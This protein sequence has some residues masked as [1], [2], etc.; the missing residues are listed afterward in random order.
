MGKKLYI[1]EKPS[2]AASF[3]EVLGM[4][5]TKQD[6]SRGYAESEHSVVTWCFG[7]LITMAYPDAYDPKYREWKVE[8]LPIIPEEYKYIV[9]DDQGVKKQFETIKT[10]MLRED[11]DLIYAC[12]DSGREGEYIYRLVYEQSGSNKS[13]R[14]VW[15]SSQTEESVK[16]GIRNAKDISEYDSLA[17]AAYSRAKEDWLFGMNFSRIYTCLYGRK[18]S[19]LLKESKSSV[20]AIGRVM[21]CV[22]GLVVDREQEIRNFVPKKHYGIAASFLSCDSNLLYKGRWVPQDKK[23]SKE[24]DKEEKYISREEAQKV[25]EELKGHPGKIKKVEVKTKKEQPPLLFNLAELQSE[26]NK[27]FKLPVDKTLEIAQGLYE[28]KLITYP[29]TDSRVLSTDVLEEIPK[30]LNGL[31]KNAEY[32]DYVLKIKE[33][34]DL[35]VTKSTK[36]YVD[37]SKVTDHYAI[38]PTY[39]TAET[40]RMD[41]NTRNVYN[42]IVK[43]FLAI[44]FPPAVYNT[45]RVETAVNKEIFV[46]NAKTLKEAG[47][48]E[49]YEVSVAK[50]DEEL[51]EVPIHL[52]AKNEAAEVKDFELEEKETKPPSRYTDG[53]LIITMEKAGKFIEDEELREQIKTSGI[54]TSATRAGIIKKLKDI[55]YIRINS[56]TQVVTPTIKGEAI[57]EVVRRTAKELLSPSLTASWEKGLAMIENKET[58]QEVFEEKLYAYINKTINKVKKSGGSIDL[59]RIIDAEVKAK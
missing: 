32:K 12:T 39:V 45:V 7:H 38:I 8:H 53:S 9:I 25:I 35:K 57:V 30:V 56:K 55:G 16:E 20:I 44:F 31:Y 4:N 34:G 17:Q 58:T 49:V 26:A 2:V 18:V 1:T 24:A 13:A 47:W 46:S 48:K 29:R 33:M 3:A 54:G 10:L 11:I 22:L 40:A 50:Q 37:D 6:K 42:L 41:D 5:I 14:R 15:I 51:T 36:R 59:T 21:T 43:R 28:K 27:K 23:D 19:N 52:L